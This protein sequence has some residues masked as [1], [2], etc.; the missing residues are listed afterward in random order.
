M[1][2]QSRSV[3]NL[4]ALRLANSVTTGHWRSRR[5]V[6]GAGSKVCAMMTVMSNMAA[7][8]RRETIQRRLADDPATTQQQLAAELGVDQRTVSRD[9][10]KLRGAGAIGIPNLSGRGRPR[11]SVTKPPV[12]AATASIEGNPGAGEQLV[13]RLRAE[14]DAK[15][16]EP[17]A[18]EE[19][20][21]LQ[22]RQVA[23]EIAELRQ[24]VDVEG[25]TFKPSSPGGPPRLHPAIAEIRQARGVLA[26]LLSQI[27][28]EEST[29]NPIKQK[30]ANTRW[31]AHQLARARQAGGG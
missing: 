6:G 16:L 5:V 9:I 26:R 3:G 8:Q 12:N 25:S 29:R 21:L 2:E 11:G 1:Q 24:R 4:R 7:D 31:R 22:I 14:L 27:S 10:E 15:D 23:D 18:R 19:G 13:A 20:L 28:L 17:D 30:A